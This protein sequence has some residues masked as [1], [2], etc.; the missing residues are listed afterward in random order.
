MNAQVLAKRKLKISKLLA[1][2]L[3]DI[4]ML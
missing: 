2:A 4:M 3:E 1:K